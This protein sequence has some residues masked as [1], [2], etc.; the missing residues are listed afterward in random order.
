MGERE[1]KGRQKG[2]TLLSQAIIN[3]TFNEKDNLRAASSAI[4]H[5]KLFSIW[6]VQTCLG[7]LN[8]H[9]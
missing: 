6:K 2:V 4:S 1:G 3:P 7:P 9:N 5:H 8:Q